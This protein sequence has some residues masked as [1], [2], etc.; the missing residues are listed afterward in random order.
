MV[1]EH[2]QEYSLKSN[3]LS[4]IKKVFSTKNVVL[5]ISWTIVHGHRLST[6]N[7][8]CVMANVH[9]KFYN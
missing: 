1:K 5:S 7:W 6:D 4:L 3:P 8:P 9:E 2:S